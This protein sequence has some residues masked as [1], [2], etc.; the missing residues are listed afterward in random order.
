MHRRP[1]VEDIKQRL[2]RI[3]GDVVRL[4]DSTYVDTKT[5]CTFVDQDHGEFEAV[6]NN[7]LRQ[8][9]GHPKR[10]VE[11][12]KR[13]CI[14]KYGVSF[15]TQAEICKA[16]ARNTFVAHYGVDNPFQSESIKR[17]ICERNTALYGVSNPMQRQDVKQKV[18]ETNMKRY[19]VA[20]TLQHEGVKLKIR[21]TN[22]SRYGVENPLQNRDVMIRALRS[23]KK[24]KIVKHWKT[25]NELICSA[26]YEFAFVNWCNINQIDFDWQIPH[27]MPDGRTYIID[28]FIKDGEH[29][30]TW[31]EIKGRFIGDKS[32]QKWEWFN[33]LHRTC[34]QLWTLDVLINA[35]VLTKQGKP[36]H[37]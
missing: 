37:T 2:Q 27:K 30:N 16:K 26:S 5:K 31:I 21:N 11:K 18:V 10:S 13:T 22:L 25:S 23:G 19:G 15:S 9:S 32:R 28:A 35:G 12:R 24:L 6:P 20:C 7:L 8:K 3:H 36:V 4:V 1:T 29:A 33:S 34:S 17:Q 14:D